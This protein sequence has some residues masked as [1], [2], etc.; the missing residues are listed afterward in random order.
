MGEQK[1]SMKPV[2]QAC[3]EAL[4]TA[5]G[6]G[7]GQDMRVST[8]GGGFHVRWDS[9]GGATAMGQLPFFAEYLDATG[10]F[11]GWLKGCPLSYLR[12]T[13]STRPTS[14]RHSLPRSSARQRGS[15]A[16]S[17]TAL[18]RRSRRLGY[19]IATR[20]SSRCM[21]TKPGPRWATTRTSRDGAGHAIHT[22]WIGNLR[23]VLDAQLESGKRHSP[24][25][26]RPG[27]VALIERLAP[28]CRPQLV[29]GDIAFGTE[30]EMAALEAL[31]QAYESLEP[32]HPPDRQRRALLAVIVR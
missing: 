4:V 3:E 7:D 22:Y 24:A 11:E 21:A 1:F 20:R 29:R 12:R 30:G 19:S 25:H 23:L 13:T 2:V 18:P 17:C 9:R 16:T 32:A 15:R 27:L 10:L 5:G 28:A 31:E 14:G 6:S 26:S 8:P